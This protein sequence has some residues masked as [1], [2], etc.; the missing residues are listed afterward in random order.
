MQI[1][2]G[3]GL[4]LFMGTLSGL[5][6]GGGKLVVPVLVLLLGFSQQLAQGAV[7]LAFLPLAAL[8]VVQHWRQGTF[9]A[10]TAWRV[11]PTAV[12]GAA[13]GA[14]LALIISPDGL[15]R[16]YG[17][18]LVAVGLFEWFTRGGESPAAPKG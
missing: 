18:F 13:L 9:D 4:G 7:L 1:L 8:A 16:A 10:R 2:F 5:G 3:L 17:L 6:V 15:R 11:L 12:G 14:S